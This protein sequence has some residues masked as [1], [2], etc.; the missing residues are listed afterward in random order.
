MSALSIGFFLQGGGGGGGV[1]EENY[2]PCQCME[3]YHIW[4]V[5]LT[6]LELRIMC[7]YLFQ[8]KALVAWLSAC[9]RS[10]PLL[11]T[12]YGPS[13]CSD[14]GSGKDSQFDF[15]VLL[16]HKARCGAFG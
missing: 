9:S 5:T 8:L 1:P 6:L 7:S 16:L 4:R 2:S 15:K 13:C 14:P 3:R 11:V 12:V 10:S